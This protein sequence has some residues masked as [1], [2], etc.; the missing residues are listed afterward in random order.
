MVNMNYSQFLS[1]LFYGP[2]LRYYES[3]TSIDL[4]NHNLVECNRTI[5][6]LSGNLS[7]SMSLESLSF[8][9]YALYTDL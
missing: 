3:T 2:G 1:F 9:Q 4:N 6:L 7:P 5:H 8:D